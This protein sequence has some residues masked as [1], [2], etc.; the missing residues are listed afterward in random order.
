D[1]FPKSGPVQEMFDRRPQKMSCRGDQIVQPDGTVGRCRILVDK[2]TL[3]D[4]GP[5]P[6]NFDTRNMEG[7]FIEAMGCLQC[8]YFDRCGLGCFLLHDYSKRMRMDS[9]LFRKLYQKIDQLRQ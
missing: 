8:E 1:H 9:C 2:R 7:R 3:K 5:N 6:D 4:F